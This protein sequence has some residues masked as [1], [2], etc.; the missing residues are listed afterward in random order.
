MRH[1]KIILG[2]GVVASAIIAGCA[3]QPETPKQVAVVAPPP[4][5]VRQVTAPVAP[6][7]V[8]AV[9]SSSAHTLDEYKR[10]VARQIVARNSTSIADTLPPILKSVIVLEITVDNEGKPRHVGVFRSNGYKDLEQVAMESVRRSGPF[11]APSSDVLSGSG[12]VTYRET[13][14]FRHDGRYQVRSALEAQGIAS[15]K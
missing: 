5:P 14:L 9:P 4:A 3:T 8:R 6:P 2:I 7:V 1:T 10:D 15:K 12:E 11:L 13:W